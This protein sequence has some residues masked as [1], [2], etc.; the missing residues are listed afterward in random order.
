MSQCRSWASRRSQICWSSRDC[1]TRVLACASSASV[2]P[3]VVALDIFAD[4]VPRDP[5]VSDTNFYNYSIGYEQKGDEEQNCRGRSRGSIDSPK[6]SI[7]CFSPPLSLTTATAT[8]GLTWTICPMEKENWA[9]GV[10][11][12]IPWS[13]RPVAHLC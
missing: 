13:V 7:V 8:H 9:S 5:Q 1:V 12:P 4:G 6:Y 3:G 10:D 11:D 2:K